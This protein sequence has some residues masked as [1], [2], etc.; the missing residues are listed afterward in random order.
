MATY[1]KEDV[2]K[3]V[4]EAVAKAVAEAVAPLLAKIDKL[5]SE[6]RELRRENEQLRRE[7][8]HM[9][10]LVW[11]REA[12]AQVENFFD[13]LNALKERQNAVNCHRAA[14]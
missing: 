6:N 1:T 8:E 14:C 2:E 12:L 7:N 4:A 10:R 5:E 11:E 13:G 3:F 9:K